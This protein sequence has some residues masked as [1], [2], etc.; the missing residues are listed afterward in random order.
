MTAKV[1]NILEGFVRLL[2]KEQLL[3][4]ARF[5]TSVSVH[6]LEKTTPKPFGYFHMSHQ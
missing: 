5:L 1:T 2:I 6:Q 3:E 4:D